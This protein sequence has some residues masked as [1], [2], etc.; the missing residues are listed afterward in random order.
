MDQD[1]LTTVLH[2]LDY[3]REMNTYVQGRARSDLVADPEGI[4]VDQSN[5]EPGPHDP[6]IAFGEN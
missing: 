1:D 6:R 5:G 4:P 3:P 2:M